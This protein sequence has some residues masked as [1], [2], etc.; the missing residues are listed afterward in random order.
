LT[1]GGPAAAPAQEIAHHLRCAFPGHDT[2]HEH[3]C[4]GATLVLLLLTACSGGEVHQAEILAPEFPGALLSIR[5]AGHCTA[6]GCPFEYRVRIT[7]PTGVDANVQVCILPS[8]GMRLP[9]MGFAGFGIPAHATKTVFA[10]FLLPGTKRDA[11]ARWAGRNLSC[12]G[13]DWHGDPPI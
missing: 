7:N 13:L 10:R 3:F 9:V 12:V 5:P 6:D 4:L 1:P 11:A 8:A 2:W